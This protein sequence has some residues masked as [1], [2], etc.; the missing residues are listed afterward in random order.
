MMYRN[1]KQYWNKR[2]M[3]LMEILIV[4]SL[5]SMLSLAIYKSLTNGL[6]VWERSNQMVVE[7]D[8]LV[9]FDKMARDVKNAYRHSLVLF[10]G[11][12]MTF[13]FPSVVSILPDVQSGLPEDVFVEQLGKVEYY[14]DTLHKTINRRQ[15]GYGQALQR[16]FSPPRIMAQSVDRVRF[17]YYYLADQNELV[18][19]KVLDTM[20]NGVEVIVKFSDAKGTRELKKYISI[21]IGGE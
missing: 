12:M 18:S 2:G 9:F 21:P 6:R 20:P 5:M 11:G 15:A 16:Q 13:A 4:V 1:R 8:I 19:E 17:L 10:E 7:E 14:Y 3:T